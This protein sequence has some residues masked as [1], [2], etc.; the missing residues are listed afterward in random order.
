MSFFQKLINKVTAPSYDEPSIVK[1]QSRVRGWLVQRRFQ[2]WMDDMPRIASLLI[3][4][5]TSE[6]EYINLLRG[7][8]KHFITPLLEKQGTDAEL[9]DET[10]H[11]MMFSY[12]QDIIQLNQKF[13]EQL[14]ERIS[15]AEVPAPMIG[16]L[17]LHWTPFLRLYTQY[18]ANYGTALVTIATCKDNV[19]EFG[20]FIDDAYTKL[21]AEHRMV[22][23]MEFPDTL[24]LPGQRI[25]K[26]TTLFHAIA[27]DMEYHHPDRKQI[28]ESLTL[29]NE[30]EEGALDGLRQAKN[31]FN[32]MGIART[33]TGNFTILKNLAVPGR[34][35]IKQGNVNVKKLPFGTK[36]IRFLLLSDLLLIGHQ[37]KDKTN[38]TDIVEL[39]TAR[40][41][42]LAHK[43]AGKDSSKNAFQVVGPGKQFSVLTDTAQDKSDWM[44]SIKNA[45]VRLLSQN[46]GSSNASDSYGWHHQIHTGSIHSAALLGDMSKLENLLKQG[47]PNA[48][49]ED[50]C[51]ALHYAAY[52][53]HSKMC[54]TLIAKGAGVN[55]ID[56]KQWT[57]LHCAAMRGHIPCIKVLLG[58]GADALWKDKNGRS[59]IHLAAVNNRSEAVEVIAS[60]LKSVIRISKEVDSTDTA[61]WTALHAVCHRGYDRVA[62]Q[63]VEHGSEINRRNDSDRTP[64]HYAA[65]GGY[66]NLCVY[67]VEHGA[68]V[69]AVD[70]FGFSPLHIASMANQWD[71][72][73]A[74]VSY[75]G[76]VKLVD[77]EGKTPIDPKYVD[78]NILLRVNDATGRWERHPGND[79]SVT[80]GR[81]TE[82]EWV[83][84]DAS[85]CCLVCSRRFTELYRRHHCR[86]CGSLICGACSSKKLA[87]ENF[88]N[89]KKN[90]VCD[91]CFNQL[92]AKSDVRQQIFTPRQPPQHNPEEV[93][94][95]NRQQLFDGR[96]NSDS[97]RGPSETQSD[98]SKRPQSTP[99]A[100]V[101]AT[102][103]VMGDN[104][105]KMQEQQEKLRNV[106]D[107]TS[108]LEDQSREFLNTIRE[109]N[110]EQANK[111]W[112]QL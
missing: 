60:H 49:D 53:G 42:D 45:I 61:G 30:V 99:A 52:A 59:A 34:Y 31:Q 79:G 87:I 1:I 21:A 35:E 109:F 15:K 33:L 102:R 67:L 54:E 72:L 27:K 3:G 89:K 78:S 50:E 2:Q 77:N 51:T 64:L 104:I 111:K 10:E 19:P 107:K 62:A 46:E 24:A 14:E 16:D 28:F 23:G 65:G 32:L 12:L 95:Q 7:I 40:I 13:L 20:A 9:L 66:L 85:I 58:K 92:N 90:R 36:T 29:L 69:N 63:L 48:P 18:A 6:K 17:I 106:A 47:D 93:A 110:K 112:Y 4:L 88:S 83:P 108:E 56:A 105:Q 76:H 44:V 101:N 38:I 80:S 70:S 94:Q 91:S 41:E 22:E 81:K 103:G 100:S 74:L 96:P 71:I 82:G 43:D 55:N 98:G 97:G 75:G 68:H 11:F 84:D 86:H 25:S 37:E 73:V 57:P 8:E 39:A 5:T 26:Y